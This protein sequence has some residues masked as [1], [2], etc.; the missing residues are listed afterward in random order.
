M[1]Y[2]AVESSLEAYYFDIGKYGQRIEVV[3]KEVVWV[4][5]WCKGFSFY[6]QSKANKGKMCKH[7]K[8]AIKQLKQDK[9]IK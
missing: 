5:C 3:D 9:I 1:K 6:L 7:L 8:A 2:I 4:N